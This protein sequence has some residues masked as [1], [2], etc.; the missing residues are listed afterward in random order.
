MLSTLCIAGVIALLAVHR[1]LRRFVCH[2]LGRHLLQR[3]AKRKADVYEKLGVVPKFARTVGFFHPYC[4]AGGGGERVLWTAVKSVQTDFPNVISLIYTG[5]PV[6]SEEAL[7]R[8]KTTFEIDLDSSKVIFVPLKLRFLVSPTVWP[9][10]TLLGQS[11]GS[12]ILGFEAICRFAPDIFID[13]MGYAFTFVIVKGFLNIPVGAYV[14]YPTISS[15]MLKSLKKV[16][17]VSKVKGAYWRWFAKIY[18]QAGRHADF[19]M[20]NSSWTQNHIASLWGKDINLS[21]VF[22]PCNTSELEKVDIIRS[23]EPNILYLAQYR[24]EKNH[25]ELLHSFALYIG[26]HPDSPAK[27]LLVGSVRNEIDMKLVES[28]K[29]LAGEL[30]ILDKVEFIVDAPWPKVVEYLGTCSIGVNYMW[31]EHFGI[32]VVEYMAAGLIP[33]VNNSG[34]PKFDIVIPWIGKPTGFHATTI[35][36]YAEAYHKA[37]T[38]SP[39]EQQEMRVNAR[40]ACARFGEHVFMRD[41][42]DVFA[43]LLREVYAKD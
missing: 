4:N 36:E 29:Q 40:S 18:S 6:S 2:A 26:K 31:N 38:L 22:P 25:K 9:R 20:T 28:L 17:I 41:F 23:R 5:D 14:H 16:S 30:K 33:V 32:G 1:E 21:V 11:V 42:G 7:R 13:T 35:G 10:F 37:L 43:K 39:Q 19:V 3:V 24:P 8:V 15:D 12:M 34:G 27:L